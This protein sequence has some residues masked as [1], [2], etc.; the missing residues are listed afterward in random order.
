MWGLGGTERYTDECNSGVGG[1]GDRPSHR[2]GKEAH[3]VGRMPA[4]EHQ[5]MV[6]SVSRIKG[7]WHLRYFSLMVQPWNLVKDTY[8]FQAC[9]TGD[10]I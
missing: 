9:V 4:Q 2:A 8:R 3:L 5:G 10:V 1:A 7:L 6:A